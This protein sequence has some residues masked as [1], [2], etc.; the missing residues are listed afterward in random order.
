MIPNS[1]FFDNKHSSARTTVNSLL[2]EKCEL[3]F[4]MFHVPCISQI[5]TIFLKEPTNLLGFIYVT[6]LYSSHQ[7]VSANHVAIFK[8]MRT[9][10]LIMHQN[11][12]T[13]KII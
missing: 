13:V 8:V 9:N 11:H 5:Y 7:H 1:K 10:T 6:L 12:S 4:N 2:L 3:Y